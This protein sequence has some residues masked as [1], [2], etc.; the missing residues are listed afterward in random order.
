MCLLEEL[1][2]LPLPIVREAVPQQ[3]LDALDPSIPGMK[4]RMYLDEALGSMV[5]LMQCKAT[6]CCLACALDI[7]CF[8]VLP[9]CRCCPP[10]PALP[11]CCPPPV[12]AATGTIGKQR[13]AILRHLQVVPTMAGAICCVAIAASASPFALDS[14]Q[15]GS[16]IKV[17]ASALLGLGAAWAAAAPLML[18]Q[19]YSTAVV[20]TDLHRSVPWTPEHVHPPTRLN[21]FF[22][23]PEYLTEVPFVEEEDEEEE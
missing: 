7:R 21:R 20:F 16:S 22:A 12:S 8:Q 1:G 4:G 2:A 11:P 9:S 6:M 19:A 14:I 17:L 5:D 3:F 23:G 10:L 18:F 13:G 15:S